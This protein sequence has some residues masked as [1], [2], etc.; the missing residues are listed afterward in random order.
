MAVD[1]EK[2]GEVLARLEPLGDVTGKAMFGGFGFW[3][4][5][6]MF[7]CMGSDGVLYFKADAATEADYTAHGAHQFAPTM[8]SGRSS[9]MPYWSVPADVYEADDR[10]EDWARRAIAVGHATARPKRARRRAP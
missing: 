1:R 2:A 9:A 3:E 8:P 7:A 4:A 5:G 10:F 6:H